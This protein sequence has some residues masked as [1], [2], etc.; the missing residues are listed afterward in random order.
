MD[1]AQEIL[2]ILRRK[3]PIREEDFASSLIAKESKDPFRVL[4]VTI[5]S[6]NCTDIASIRAYRRLEDQVGVTI[7]KLSEAKARAIEKAI[8]VAGLHRQKARAL[9]QIA[10][11]VTAKYSGNLALA[12]RGPDEEV[13]NRLQELPKVGPKTADVLLSIWGRPTISVDTHVD[14]VSKRFG[15]AS[16]KAK[17]DEVR[18][19]LMR[20]FKKEDYYYVPLYFM[21]HGRQTCKARRPICPT[22]PVEKLCPYPNKTR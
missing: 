14:R 5:L 11:I 22:C 19:A 18:A 20:L 7:P 15:F 10:R 6:Q 4:V 3:L 21:A 8:R 2:N 1:H 9:K 17:Y 12:L 13:R 16:N